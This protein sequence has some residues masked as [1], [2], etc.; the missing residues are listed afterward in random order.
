MQPPHL[1]S[2]VLGVEPSVLCVVGKHFPKNHISWPYNQLFSMEERLGPYSRDV[3][4]QREKVKFPMQRRVLRLMVKF[5]T[6][7]GRESSV[8]SLIYQGDTRLCKRGL[9]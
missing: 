4:V 7:E 5:L 6:K 3:V 9:R 1:V 2:A 8:Q